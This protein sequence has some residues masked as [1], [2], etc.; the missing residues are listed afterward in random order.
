MQRF[1]LL[2][3]SQACAC[4]NTTGTAL[5]KHAI[6]ETIVRFAQIKIKN[7]SLLGDHVDLIMIVKSES[8]GLTSLLF[9]FLQIL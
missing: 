1:A 9:H 4:L 8:I 6:L 3:P 7:Y 5:Y 2:G